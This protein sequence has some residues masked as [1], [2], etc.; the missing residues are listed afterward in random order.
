MSA[1]EYRRDRLLSSLQQPHSQDADL[2][3]PR[4]RTVSFIEPSK[5]LAKEESQDDGSEKQSVEEDETQIDFLKD[6]GTCC[7]DTVHG[8][9]HQCTD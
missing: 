2:G 5:P 8:L 7:V 6:M 1:Q 4:S 9:R 3:T